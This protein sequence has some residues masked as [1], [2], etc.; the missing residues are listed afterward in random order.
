LRTRPRRRQRD[1]S[2]VIEHLSY[3]QEEYATAAQ[4]V[5]AIRDYIGRGWDVSWISGPH[6]GTYLVRYR[7][8]RAPVLVASRSYPGSCRR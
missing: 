3:H 2:V 4:C 6:G 8:E 5:A 7:M 1:S